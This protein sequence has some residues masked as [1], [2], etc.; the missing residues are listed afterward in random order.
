MWPFY[1]IISAQTVKQYD[2]IGGDFLPVVDF[3]KLW[4]IDDYFDVIIPKL[5]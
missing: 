1:D 2:I 5:I 3:S 4:S